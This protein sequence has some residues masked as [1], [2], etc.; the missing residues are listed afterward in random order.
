MLLQ[1]RKCL[2]DTFV[3]M[4]GRCALDGDVKARIVGIDNQKSLVMEQI[5]ILLKSVFLDGE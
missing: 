5:H 3:P 1:E 4:K 2:P